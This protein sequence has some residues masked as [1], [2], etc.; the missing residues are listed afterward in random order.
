VFQDYW[1]LCLRGHP[2]RNRE[3]ANGWMKIARNIPTSA[4]VKSSSLSKQLIL[5]SSVRQ[6]V[7]FT[8]AHCIQHIATCV[9]T[10]GISTGKNA[11]LGFV[12]FDYP[13]TSLQRH[14]ATKQSSQDA[15]VTT[16]T[17]A[18]LLLKQQDA[19][20]FLQHIFLATHSL[21][22]HYYLSLLQEIRIRKSG[23]FE[24]YSCCKAVL[25][26]GY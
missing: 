20:H 10:V 13:G 4:K 15:L 8:V 18:I 21:T 1:S 14:Y 3:C 11:S 9:Y 19:N 22:K 5:F 24:G 12:D 23:I 16:S 7:S 25:S 17:D 6:Q 2:R 26:F